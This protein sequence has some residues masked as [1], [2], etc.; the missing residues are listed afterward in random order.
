MIDTNYTMSL[1]RLQ[2]TLWTVLALSAYLIIFF[3]RLT[4]LN[5]VQKLASND[6]LVAQCAQRL[7]QPQVQS[8]TQIPITTTQK[9]DMPI[10][11]ETCGGGALQIVFPEALLLAMGISLASFAGSTL[12]DSNKQKEGKFL[13]SMK[14]AVDDAA[15]ALEEAKAEQ[16]KADKELNALKQE[17]ASDWGKK[18]SEAKEKLKTAS[19]QAAKDKLEDEIAD[20][21]MQKQTAVEQAQK[22]WDAAQKKVN[23][24]KEALDAVTK[25]QQEIELQSS[26]SLFK[27]TGD[28]P[29][30]AAQKAKFSDLFQGVEVGNHNFIDMSRVQMFFFTMVIIIAYAAQ[31]N[32][33]LHDPAALRHPLGVTLPPFSESMNILLGFSHSAYLAIKNVDHTTGQTDK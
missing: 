32:T 16:A 9:I 30:E 21:E 1:S 8:Q 22:V 12:V 7:T 4:G 13:T 26:G 14:Q 17:N 20:L 28:T 19:A 23:A 6:P 27:N 25:K 18:I 3:T 11:V 5:D 2:I 33:L 15:K 31:V 24:A 29:R 10:A